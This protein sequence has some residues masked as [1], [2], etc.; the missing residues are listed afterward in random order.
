M[1]LLLLPFFHNRKDPLE[2]FDY[3]GLRC[4]PIRQ[5]ASLYAQSL[6]YKISHT[7]KPSLSWYLDVFP[8]LYRRIRFL[9]E[10]YCLYTSSHLGTRP[11]C[12]TAVNRMCKTSSKN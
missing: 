2:D 12:T 8:R 6:E 5:P 4:N 1:N 11:T 10:D 9:F 3:S 7:G